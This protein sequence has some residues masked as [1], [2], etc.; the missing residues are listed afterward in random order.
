MSTTTAANS[1]TQAPADFPACP[2][3]GHDH[4]LTLVE[5]LVQDD[6]GKVAYTVACPA[7]WYRFFY[8]EEVYARLGAEALV[9]IRRPRGG[10]GES[11]G[12]HGNPR[13]CPGCHEVLPVT[14]EC[15]NCG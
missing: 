5:R 7:G 4:A 1:S 8:V 13:A 10:W 11:A 9:K 6:T 12:R 14:G 2:I 15:G 3:R